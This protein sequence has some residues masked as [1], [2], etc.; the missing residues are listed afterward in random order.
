MRGLLLCAVFASFAFSHVLHLFA[1]QEGDNVA[2]YSYFYKN[3]PC[4]G[5]KITLSANGREILR[6]R[7]D[8]LGL[9]RVKIPAKNF[10]I[11]IYGGAGH[12]AQMEFSTEGFTPQDLSDSE[13]SEPRNSTS[14]NLNAAKDSALESNTPKGVVPKDSAPEGDAP[15]EISNASEP[16]A[17]S[18]SQSLPAKEN[19]KSDIR[20]LAFKN[21]SAEVPKIALCLALIFGFF[22]LIWLAKR[23]RK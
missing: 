17:N 2:I 10:T 7:T 1:T 4:I 19:S 15:K 16:L 23:V 6:T 13:N 20:S 9:A 5:C 14:Q 11:Q 12:G 8:E 22:A 3:S 18:A 21:Q